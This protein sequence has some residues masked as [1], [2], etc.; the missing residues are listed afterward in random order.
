MKIFITGGQGLI[1][2]HIASNL[3]K[4]GN[5]CYLFD[6]RNNHSIYFKDNN[7]IRKIT[8]NIVNEFEIQNNLEEVDGIIHLAGI[9]RVVWGEKYPDTC[10]NVNVNG[11]LN[12]LNS[13][14]KMKNKPWLIYG[15]SREVY[16][17]QTH[18]PVS[19]SVPLRPINIY[20]KTKAQCEALC[21]KFAEKYDFNLVILR[22][23][24]VYG[25]INDH[26]DRV[27]PNFILKALNG[28]DFIIQGGTQLFDFTHIDDTTNGILKTV[29][30]LSEN[31]RKFIDD[32]HLLTGKGTTLQEI[33]T[34]IQKY[35]PTESK[36]RYKPARNYDVNRFV[37]DPTKSQQYL[38]FRSKITI[39]KGIKM[40][41]DLFKNNLD[42]INNKSIETN[43]IKMLN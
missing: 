31:N 25:S 43:F 11:T 35:R 12:L 19:E 7:K 41:L 22:F 27:I 10:H 32:Y 29:K 9:S 38:G 36:I 6:I 42:L 39:E 4:N 13:L 34:L 33:I 18:L 30:I 37:G 14:A 26:F 17:E 16:G 23:S 1:G 3:T 21:R 15:S 28:E 8:G 24:N 2:S 20:G 40:T 5:I